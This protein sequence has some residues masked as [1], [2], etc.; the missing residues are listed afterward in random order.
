MEIYFVGCKYFTLMKIQFRLVIINLVTRKYVIH[1]ILYRFVEECLL[2]SCPVP[3][4]VATLVESKRERTKKLNCLSI[5]EKENSRLIYLYTEEREGKLHA[6]CQSR[7]PKPSI[8]AEARPPAQFGGRR[9]SWGQ[10]RLVGAGKVNEGRKPP[11][12]C[13]SPPTPN[14]REAT[15]PNP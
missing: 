10:T 9:G 14:T 6:D 2:C 15:G 7:S 3:P 4:L 5:Q 1:L 12:S 8:S 11:V 13:P